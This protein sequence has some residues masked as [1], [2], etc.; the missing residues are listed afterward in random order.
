[1]DVFA[2]PVLK[3]TTVLLLVTWMFNA[4]GSTIIMW[5]PLYLSEH[6]AEFTHD[7]KKVCSF[8]CMHYLALPP[9][10]ASLLRST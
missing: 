5:L 9:T 7:I 1:M 10:R 2:N 3:L 8:A 4:M 6:E